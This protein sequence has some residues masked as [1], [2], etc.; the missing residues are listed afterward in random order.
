MMTRLRKKLE[1][2]KRKLAD[3]VEAKSREAEGG[4]EIMSAELL[5]CDRGSVDSVPARL[6]KSVGRGLSGR[7]AQDDN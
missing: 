2:H 7:S 3:G 5:A 1:A 6:R 4:S